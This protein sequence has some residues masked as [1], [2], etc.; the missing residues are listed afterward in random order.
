M[1]DLVSKARVKQVLN[2]YNVS[3]D[4]YDELDEEV[5]ELLHDAARR[6]EENG[7]RTVKPRD[8]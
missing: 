2:E 3:Q 7:R 4:F 8:L 5:E 1:A 6:A